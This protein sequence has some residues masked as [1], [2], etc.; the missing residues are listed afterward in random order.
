M[1][2]SDFFLNEK[3]FLRGIDGS[4]DP[5]RM[6]HFRDALA[7]ARE[8]AGERQKTNP[9]DGEA[10]LALTLA[11]GME[12][13]AESI[14]QKRH[15]AGL[16]QMKKANGYAKELLAQHPDAADAYIAPASQITLSG[17]RALVLVSCSGLM[18]FT[19][20]KS[21]AWSKS[22]GPRKTAAISGRSPKLSLPSPRAV[23]NRMPWR[24][25]C[26]AN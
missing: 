1:L 2:T 24:K 3:K 23:K 19:A 10:R 25:D 17:R 26:S 6:S 18:E 5:G 9:N 20:T 8:L 11:A 16:K 14:L 7:R 13:D 4:P 15:L 21:S 12:S 22:Q